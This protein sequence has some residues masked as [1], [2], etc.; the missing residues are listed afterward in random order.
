MKYQ[1]YDILVFI[2]YLGKYLKKIQEFFLK[3]GIFQYIE[4][5]MKVI[6]SIFIQPIIYIVMYV[7]S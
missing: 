7:T 4:S 3:I 5:Y 2:T 1:K 6:K